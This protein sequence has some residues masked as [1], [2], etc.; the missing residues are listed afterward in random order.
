MATTSILTVLDGLP[1]FSGY[2][3]ECD[4]YFKPE[5]DAKTFIEALENYFI[6]NNIRDDKKKITILFGMVDKT[7][8]DAVQVITAL[9]EDNLVKFKDVKEEIL[10]MYPT[11][12][13]TELRYAAQELLATDLTKGPFNEKMTSLTRLT[14]AVTHAYVNNTKLTKDQFNGESVIATPREIGPE[15]AAPI[16]PA[17][18]TFKLADILQNMI[19]HLFISAQTHVKVY[20]KVKDIG[21][22]TKATRFMSNT[23]FKAL[24][25]KRAHPA[26]N[27]EKN[28]DIV[29]K[30]DQRTSARSGEGHKTPR[31]VRPSQ[32]ENTRLKCFNCNELGH[33]KRDC[34]ICGYCRKNGHTAK[35]CEERIKNSKGKYCQE[36]DL[37]DS[38]NTS[39]CY[40][41]SKHP[42]QKSRPRNDVRMMAGEGKHPECTQEGT[43][44]SNAYESTEDDTDGGD[45]NNL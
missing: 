31:H 43:W 39:E 4:A 19:M 15:N 29:F 25:Y 28:N 12:M 42:Q 1:T 7:K 18:T 34:K 32:R 3:R 38:H 9:A 24:E 30:L 36:C 45:S 8:G 40:K 17:P 21:P 37:K 23:V 33:S 11:A 41:N 35:G 6:Q 5:V 16:P 27:P 10:E 26:K 14:R 44:A 13:H 22:S 2:P 20:E